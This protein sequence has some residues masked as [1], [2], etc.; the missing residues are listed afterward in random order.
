MRIKVLH[1][2]QRRTVVNLPQGRYHRSGTSQKECSG[3]V[4][5]ALLPLQWAHR[6]IA[7]RKDYQIRIEPELYNFRGLQK[8]V[9]SGRAVAQQNQSRSIWKC[10]VRKPMNGEMNDAVLVQSRAFEGGFSC[11][12]PQQQLVFL[13]RERG[14]RDPHFICR[15][16]E[17]DKAV[18]IEPPCQT[19]PIHSAPRI[20]DSS[21]R[22]KRIV[23]CSWTLLLVPQQVK[24]GRG[25]GID[26]RSCFS[27]IAA[28][29]LYEPVERHQVQLS[30]R[31]NNEGLLLCC[32]AD[33]P[34]DRVIQA[35]SFSNS[36]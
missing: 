16:R 3:Q 20:R 6:R 25:R 15:R 5:D 36:G 13:F 8:S 29:Y 11:R 2:E 12:R 7:G 1:E 14:L 30:V 18:P 31:D 27:D 19:R 24:T 10:G 32:L 28:G 26:D 23:G 22:E 33:R 35:A 21:N 34:K 4:R 9:L 17:I